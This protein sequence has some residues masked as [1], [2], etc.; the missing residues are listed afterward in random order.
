MEGRKALRRGHRAEESTGHW[1]RSGILRVPYRNLVPGGKSAG[2]IS[3]AV[4]GQ[5]TLW[6]R[7][8]VL[9]CS[10]RPGGSEMAQV[11]SIVLSHVTSK[12]TK[13]TKES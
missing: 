13:V 2:N 12:I 1:P 4:G 5:V 11:E 9:S 6:L 3:S 10:Q 7:M 8:V